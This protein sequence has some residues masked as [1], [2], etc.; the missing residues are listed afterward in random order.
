MPRPAEIR[1]IATGGGT[2]AE[3][4][5]EA[6]WQA[7][8]DLAVRE[9]GYASPTVSNPALAETILAVFGS[10]ELACWTELTPEMWAAKRKEF[11]RVYRLMAERGETAPQRLVGY[12]ER[13]NTEHGFAGTAM[14]TLPAGE[15]KELA[16]PTI[17]PR[18]DLTAEE[19]AQRVASVQRGLEAAITRRDAAK[20]SPGGEL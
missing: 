12:C 14:G 1:A 5:T 18:I 10:W 6:A 13:T 16:A 15:H 3:L 8:R 7:Y 2:D 11:G 9:G 20:G 4:V 19:H 17:G